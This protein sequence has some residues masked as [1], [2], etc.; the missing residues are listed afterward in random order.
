MFPSRGV[1]AVLRSGVSRRVATT[2]TAAPVRAV[3]ASARAPQE[4]ATHTHTHTP[5]HSP[6]ATE[7][8]LVAGAAGPA[9]ESRRWA[10]TATPARGGGGGGGATVAAGGSAPTSGGGGADGGDGGLGGDDRWREVL[11]AVRN[12]RHVHAG[13][14]PGWVADAAGLL[15]ADTIAQVDDMIERLDVDL[16]VEVAVVTLPAGAMPA[17][18]DPGEFGVN[19]FNYWGI[20]HPD[21]NNGMLVCRLAVG[22]GACVGGGGAGR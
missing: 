14:E 17:G 7:P 4:A 8:R 10:S 22:V 20:G 19:L 3:G 2:V 15:Q 1:A 21:T 12:P 13:G 5:W 11:Q 9:C 16:N 18:T 6:Q